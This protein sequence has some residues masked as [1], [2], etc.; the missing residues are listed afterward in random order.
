MEIRNNT[1]QYRNTPAFG[2]AFLKPS[3]ARKTNGYVAENAD[4][5]MEAFEKAV[6]DGE[7]QKRMLRAVR[8]LI[9]K[10][11]NDGHYNIRFIADSSNSKGYS[12]QIIDRG[13]GRV[14]EETSGDFWSSEFSYPKASDYISHSELHGLSLLGKAKAYL[15][16]AKV[17]IAN[18]YR[19]IT[20]PSTELPH[21]IQKMSKRVSELE[22]AA[23]IKEANIK[24]ANRIF[25]KG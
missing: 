25:D 2:M 19:I 15:K 10:H 20:K 1:P 8:Q 21:T 14:I 4:A 3:M 7:P 16:A 23:N 6:F 18:Q 12:V 17:V 5:A 24:Q 9:Y 13:I 11:E 22:E